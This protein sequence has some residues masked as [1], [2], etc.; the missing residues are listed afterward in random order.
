MQT[1]VQNRNNFFRMGKAQSDHHKEAVA[2]LNINNIRPNFQ[3][4][5]FQYV[6]SIFAGT[7]FAVYLSEDIKKF[8]PQFCLA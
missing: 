3:E 4:A 2:W 7:V 1:T 5:H 6:P 8:L